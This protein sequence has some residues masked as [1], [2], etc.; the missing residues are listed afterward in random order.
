MNFE[1]RNFCNISLQITKKIF[2]VFYIH[3]SQK[4]YKDAGK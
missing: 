1:L 4:E 3:K 2:S